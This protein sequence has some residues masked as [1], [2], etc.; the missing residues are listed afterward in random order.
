MLNSSKLTQNRKTADT[1]ISIL[2]EQ[3]YF[4]NKVTIIGPCEDNEAEVETS[5]DATHKLQMA[6]QED[7]VG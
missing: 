5:L 3:H 1:S 4:R 2:G 6:W 7:Y